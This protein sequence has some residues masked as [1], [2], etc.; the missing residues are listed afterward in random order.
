MEGEK[1]MSWKEM[2]VMSIREEFVQ[3]GMQ[4]G[5]NIRMLCRRYEISSRTAY[6]WIQR[7]KQAGKSGLADRSKRPERSPK[8]TAEK[9][10]RL[11]LQKR[12]ETGWGGR[13]IA[14]VLRDEKQE[15]VPHPNTITD[16]LRRNGK[17]AV[18]ESQKH[19]TW[20]RY[21]RDRPNELWQMDFKGHFGMLQGR[22]HPLTLLDDHSRFCLG[23]RA[24]GDETMETIQPHLA[25]IFRLYGLPLALLCDNGAPWGSGYPHL[26][27]TR[28]TVWLMRLGIRVTHGRP[29]H[30]QTQ[31]KDERFHR[32]LK[33][34][35][36]QGSA[37]AD[38]EDC[39][40]HFDPFRERYNLVRPHEALGM[41]TPGQH[42]QPSQLPFPE[43]L[44]PVEYDDSQ[45]VRKVQSRG[46]IYF[47][48]R[49]FRVGKAL[50]GQPV[51]LCSTEVDGCFD[52]FFCTTKVDQINFAVLP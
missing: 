46:I 24:C 21:E 1:A 50:Q 34:E 17:I 8:R 12:A 15:N 41:D 20:Q 23:L 7:Y 11:V 14:R 27:L 16:I 48:N 18:D 43:V 33:A 35:V 47:M 52:V 49:E 32:T 37:F 38:L 13:K 2:D 5:S 10:E 9:M 22:C 3:L 29:N 26:E 6:K 45:I 25:S 42:Y 30:P 4:K 39:Q 28:L 51:R 31:G 44:P 40:R 19:T 36:L